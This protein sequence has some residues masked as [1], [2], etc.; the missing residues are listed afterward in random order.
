MI[1]LD[2]NSIFFIVL[3]LPFL[4]PLVFKNTAFDNVDGIYDIL[5][6]ASFSIITLL[7]IKKNK[8]N[9]YKYIFSLIL[10]YIMLAIS[11]FYNM[12]SW[13]DMRALIGPVTSI[14]GVTLVMDYF[15]SEK[16]LCN[17]IN[18]WY[19]YIIVNF[20]VIILIPPSGIPYNDGLA[21]YYSGIENDQYFLG[22]D[23][24]FA[25]T[26]VPALCIQTILNKK[27]KKFTFE[28][29]TY[30]LYCLCILSLYI[31]WSV[32]GLIGVS[33]LI[34][35][36][37]LAARKKAETDKISII[38]NARVATIII[39]IL[40]IAIVRFKI[41]MVFL[42]FI[43]GTFEKNAT[44]FSRVALWDN[45]LKSIGENPLLGVGYHTSKRTIQM[46]GGNAHVHNLLLNIIYKGGV[47][48]F[49]LFGYNMGLVIQNLWKN[50]YNT[51]SIVIV[52]ALFF[53]FVLS[54]ADSYDDAQF[55]ILLYVAYRIDTI[56][57]WS[58]RTVV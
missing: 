26:F 28:V 23:N 7:T 33:G 17:L 3:I 1:K 14:I 51:I 41:Y 43:Q 30:I 52:I 2:K 22:M 38:I 10:Y 49:M 12:E 53:S 8:V 36:Y 18:I 5:K 39:I 31:T 27:S 32:G 20:I 35:V 9:S 45:A 56:I 29:K 25:F 46:L 11:T 16:Q 55:Y 19:I 6:I 42:D 44:L 37:I 47:L 58:N 54:L 40:E 50:R 4:E 13:Q 48:S 15:F 57:E 21:R 34:F 24:R